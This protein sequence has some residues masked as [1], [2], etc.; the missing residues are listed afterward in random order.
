MK[1][2]IMFVNRSYW[3][4]VEATGQLLTELC[5]SLSAEF[6]VSVVCGQPVKNPSNSEFKRTGVELHKGVKIIRVRHTTFGKSSLIGRATNMVTFLLSAT[7]KSLRC[8]RP[9]TIVIETDPPLLCFLGYLMQ[10]IRRCE[11]ICYLQDIYPD[12]AVALGKFPDGRIAK[13]LRAGFFRVY[14][15]SDRVVVLSNDMKQLMID[16]GVSA[17][18]VSIVHNWVDTEVVFPMKENNTFRDRH[19]MNE[20]F[21]VMYSGNMGFSQNLGVI[22]DAAELLSDDDEILFAMVGDG[23]MRSKLEQRVEDDGQANV[24]FFDYQPKEEL[25]ESLSAADLQVVVLQPHITQ[26]L[27]PSKIYG[28]LAAG[29]CPL[30]IADPTSDLCRTVIEHEAGVVATPNDPISIA[31]SIRAAK[32]ERLGLKI[33]GENARALACSQ[34]TQAKSVSEFGELLEEGYS[35]R[36]A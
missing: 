22:L 31:E 32:A 10:R 4:D 3:P 26:M 21:V 5:E 7:L 34:Y 33:A 35:Q 2:S 23:A 17:E 8:K 27:M 13:I 11:L 28:V 6:D 14:K 25:A 9:D 18:R 16:G 12:I 29:T 1:K 36:A 15:K 30:V 24:R 20:K 19:E